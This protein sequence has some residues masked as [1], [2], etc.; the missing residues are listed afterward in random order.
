MG[1]G[2]GTDAAERLRDLDDLENFLRSANS[3]ASLA[4][5]DL[6]KVR[7]HLGDDAARSLERLSQLAKQLTD[8]GLI[9]PREGRFELTPQ[10]IRRIGQ[11]SPGRP[12]LPADKD[13]VGIAPHHMDGHRARSRGD[14]Q[15]LRV[16]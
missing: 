7:R 12:V 1:M 6:D 3:P 11:Q 10:G 9:D 16:R 4:E 8:A 2:D 14:D 5:V 13:R 15:A